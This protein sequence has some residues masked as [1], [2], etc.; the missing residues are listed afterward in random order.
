MALVTDYTPVD[1]G[2]HTLTLEVCD[3]DDPGLCGRPS[4]TTVEVLNAPSPGGPS[5]HQ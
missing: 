2:T 5:R 4:E 3:A 1:D